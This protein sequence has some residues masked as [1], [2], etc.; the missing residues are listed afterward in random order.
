MVSDHELI[1][2]LSRLLNGNRDDR[3]IEQLHNWSQ[4]SNGQNVIQIVIQQGKYNTNIGEGEDIKIGDFLNTELL[5]EI[6]DLLRSRSVTPDLDINWQEMSQVMLEEY[7]RLT[8]NPLTAG[9]GIFYS[10]DRV[11]VPLGLVERKRKPRCREDVSPEKGSELYQETEITQ[12]FENEEFLEQVLKLRQSP[13]SQGKRIAIIGEPGAGKTTLLQQIAQWITKQVEDAIVIWVSLADLRG[14][15]LEFYLLERWLQA[16]TRRLGQAEVTPQVKDT[17]VAQFQQGRVWLLLDGVDEMQVS[18]GSPLAEIS[19]QVRMGGLLSQAKIVLTCRVNLWDNNFNALNTFD[20]YRTLEFSYPQQVEQFIANWFGSLPSAENHI[21]Q[22]LCATL[23]ESGKERIQDL[24]K[25]PLRLTLLC[26][27]W[28]LGEGKLPETKAGLYEQFVADFYEW[29]KGQFKTTGEQRK[30]LNAALGELAREAIDKEATR[31]RLRQEFVSEYLGEPDDAD[32]LFW[33]AL[34][35]GW[36]NKVGV[37]GSNPREGVYAFFHPTFQEYFAALAINYCHYFLN[38]IPENPSHPDASYRIFEPQWKEIFLLW[39]GQE[40][41]S[42]KHKEEFFKTLVNFEDVWEDF[43]KYR[44]Y[45][46]AACGTNEFQDCCLFEEIMN[47]LIKWGFDDVN[48]EWHLWHPI[49][50]GARKVIQ[51]MEKKRTIKTLINL[52][53]ITH[54]ELTRQQIAETLVKIDSANLEAINALISYLTINENSQNVQNA[55]WS[56]KEV[57]FGN[58]KIVAAVTHLLMTSKDDK[59]ILQSA[60]TLGHIDPGNHE[61]I[62]TMIRLIYDSQEQSISE[63]AIESLGRIGI[64]NS[65]VISTLTNLLNTSQDEYVRLTAAESLGKIDREHSIV[66]NVLLTLLGN[67]QDEHIRLLS[68]DS[69]ALVDPGNLEAMNFLTQ[70][71]HTASDEHVRCLA[72]ESLGKHDPENYLYIATL[73]KS[74]INGENIAWR[75]IEILP[76]KFFSTVVSD[77]KDCLDNQL[78]ENFNLNSWDEIFGDDSY[79]I[80]EVR[81]SDNF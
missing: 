65:E 24:V 44:A 48:L 22:R 36:L 49:A 28:Y 25:N 66:I 23:R 39:L 81:D 54:D 60:E 26:F 71:I 35:L 31:F 2:I 9:E 72:A 34:R 78:Y 73:V 6:R 30:C 14:H 7:Q 41:I 37:D 62:F 75:L 69:L 43:Y 38:H 70:Q 80:L 13:K 18:S 17:F 29:N 68:A 12:R 15:E 61:A 57:G 4:T 42:K 19:Q 58:P 79:D 56:L 20:P 55:L 32:S 3:D 59:I 27:D 51:Q 50:E 45:F 47:H 8:T 33:L 64:G 76:K 46:L 1:A 10:S 52:L 5:E 63:Q 16:V 74:L 53:N 11:Y 40:N 21:G 77:L 67:S